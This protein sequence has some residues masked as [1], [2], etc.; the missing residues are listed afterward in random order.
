[1]EWVGIKQCDLE[2]ELW[3][4]MS[5]VCKEGQLCSSKE[6]TNDYTCQNKYLKIMDFAKANNNNKFDI[7]RFEK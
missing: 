7:K 4:F 6:L 3:G 2:Y 5:I 1:M